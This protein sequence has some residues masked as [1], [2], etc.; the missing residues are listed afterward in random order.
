[1]WLEMQLAD[2]FDHCVF[3]L[4]AIVGHDVGRRRVLGITPHCLDRVQ[5]G[6]VGGQPFDAQPRRARV[7]SPIGVP[8][9]VW[10]QMHELFLARLHVADEAN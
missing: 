4:R 8:F 1:M 6:R 10:Q 7:G 2:G 9:G 5:V 3:E